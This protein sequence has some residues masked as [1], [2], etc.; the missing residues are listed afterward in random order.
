MERLKIGPREGFWET[1]NG[2]EGVYYY[3]S[4]NRRIGDKLYEFHCWKES[5]RIVFKAYEVKDWPEFATAYYELVKRIEFTSE[6]V[7]ESVDENVSLPTELEEIE[8]LASLARAALKDEA[9]GAFTQAIE[10][11]YERCNKV[12]KVTRNW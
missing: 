8:R 11:M 4:H 12:F 5:N 1:C 3:S 6:P 2:G 10:Q 7:K 9:E